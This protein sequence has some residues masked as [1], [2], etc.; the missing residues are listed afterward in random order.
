[1]TPAMRQVLAEATTQRG[2][3]L[4]AL[5]GEGPLLLVFLRHFG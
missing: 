1:M 2:R 3:T 5:A 4:E